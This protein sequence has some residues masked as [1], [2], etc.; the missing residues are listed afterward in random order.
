MVGERAHP[1]SCGQPVPGMQQTL[2]LL[3][4]GITEP[5]HDRAQQQHA[6]CLPTLCAC[7]PD[8][9]APG[10]APAVGPGARAAGGTSTAGAGAGAADVAAAAANSINAST[11]K[12]MTAP[13]HGALWY[14][15]GRSVLSS[16]LV[17]GQTFVFEMA[18]LS[19][20]PSALTTS[21]TLAEMV[22]LAHWRVLG[23]QACL[24]SL[25]GAALV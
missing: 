21:V 19:S 25:L 8:R 20:L 14:P 13:A 17:C 22:N 16:V 3:Q 1:F 10:F 4:H 15:V 6:G 2:L 12:L 5:D 24:G 7:L 11:M 23:C 18:E 9:G